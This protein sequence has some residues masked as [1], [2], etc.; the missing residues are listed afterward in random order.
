MHADI[1]WLAEKIFAQK[2]SI[3]IIYD[4]MSTVPARERYKRHANESFT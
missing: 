3:C 4:K 2:H 1:S